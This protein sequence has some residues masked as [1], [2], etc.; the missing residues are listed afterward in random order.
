MTPEPLGVVPLGTKVQTNYSCLHQSLD[1]GGSCQ[2][3]AL[4]QAATPHPAPGAG[5]S[6][7]PAEVSGWPKS[8]FLTETFIF[9]A[10][11]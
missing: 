6:G 3:M 2:S 10:V 4:G 1:G 8:V 11:F 9:P 5:A 7:L